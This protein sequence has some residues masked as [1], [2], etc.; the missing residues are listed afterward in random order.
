MRGRK[1]RPG[2]PE[3]PQ[4]LGEHLKKRRLDLG[5]RQK[6]AAREVGAN[7]K[8]YENWER[9]RY[10]PEVRFL[11]AVIAFLGYD[12]APVGPALPLGERIRAARRRQ[13]LT[14][15]ELAYRLGIDPS[16]VA[17]WETGTVRKPSPRFARLFEEYA[18]SS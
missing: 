10:E 15:E 6:D 13:G 4:T 9:G 8:T 5:L 12:P 2:Y 18:R 7:F 11:P 14:Q 3:E 16:T 1:P 17:A